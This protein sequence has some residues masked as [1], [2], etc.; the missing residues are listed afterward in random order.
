M[1]ITVASTIFP[2]RI[3]IALIATINSFSILPTLAEQ[4]NCANYWINP[5]TGNTECFSKQMDLILEPKPILPKPLSHKPLLVESYDI[6]GTEIAIPTPDQ[7]VQV[8]KRMDAV[9]RLHSHMSDPM[10]DLL[11][12]YIPQSEVAIAMKGELPVLE[13][14][15][16]LKVNK[17]LKS[18]V[19]N[20]RDFAEF[21]SVTKSQNKEIYQSIKSKLPNILKKNSQ[22]ISKEFNV[23]VALEISQIIPLDPHYEADNTLSYSMYIIYKVSEGLQEQEY[24]TSA[25]ATAINVSGKILFLYC[26]GAQKDLEWTQNASR[27]WSDKVIASNK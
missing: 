20:S 17:N 15:F 12:S 9:N 25:T 22:G 2:L 27:A 1:N 18:V 7:Y 23:D 8:T 14:G 3:G 11:A 4:P 16:V 5:Q 6:G 24:I 13:K 19:V 26:Y 21:K 10:N